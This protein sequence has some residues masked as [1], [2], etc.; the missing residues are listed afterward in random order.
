MRYI[1]WNLFIYLLI[2]HTFIEHL[3]CSGTFTCKDS[4]DPLA[5]NDTSLVN[6]K[7]LCEYVGHSLTTV[8]SAVMIAPANRLFVPQNIRVV[9]SDLS[10]TL[11]LTKNTKVEISNIMEECE[12]HLQAANSFG[13]FQLIHHKVVLLSS[14]M[15]GASP[16][17]PF[18]ELLCSSGHLGPSLFLV[19]C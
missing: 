6:H 12:R 15:Q 10:R 11:L 7:V 8:S 17:Q 4:W 18:A 19:M 2:Q 1:A 16:L 3:L 9:Q 13:A 14:Y 5:T